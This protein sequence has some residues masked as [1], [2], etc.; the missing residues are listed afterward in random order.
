MK[1]ETNPRRRWSTTTADR[2]G[3][4]PVLKVAKAPKEFYLSGPR[5]PSDASVNIKTSGMN[6]PITRWSGESQFVGLAIISRCARASIGWSSPVLP[7]DFIGIV[8][9][10]ILDL[11]PS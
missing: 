10:N 2:I 11:P 1:A 6:A 4:I 9:E 8:V 7:K 3:E 5:I